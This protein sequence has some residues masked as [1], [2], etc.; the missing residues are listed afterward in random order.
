MEFLVVVDQVKS[1]VVRLAVFPGVDP[2]ETQVVRV[3][4]V[5]LVGIEV[6]LLQVY[7][8]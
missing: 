8:G 3:R 4:P 5:F 2:E 6:A 7:P 1:P